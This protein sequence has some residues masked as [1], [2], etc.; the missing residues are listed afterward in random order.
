MN[1]LIKGF[2]QKEAFDDIDFE[3]ILKIF[4]VVIELS[5]DYFLNDEVYTYR[6]CV[7]NILVPK[8]CISKLK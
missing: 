2:A 6:Y 3:V 5:L 1:C 8:Y 4:D 7:N